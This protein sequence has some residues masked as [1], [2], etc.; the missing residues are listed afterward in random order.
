MRRHA[1]RR[2]AAWQSGRRTSIGAA[3]IPS[4]GASAQ[5]LE[6]HIWAVRRARRRYRR[7][8]VT[9][10]EPLIWRL[11]TVNLGHAIFVLDIAL[12]CGFVV[13]APQLVSPRLMAPSGENSGSSQLQPCPGEQGRER[14]KGVLPIARQAAQRCTLHA[15]M[16]LERSRQL[17]PPPPRRC[18][19]R[20]PMPATDN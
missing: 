19:W 20:A 16:A 15:S 17:V 10:W 8:G 11:G 9:S 2:N 3:A 1:G 13:A 5:H 12:Q 6:L 4:S 18:H 7:V 14:D